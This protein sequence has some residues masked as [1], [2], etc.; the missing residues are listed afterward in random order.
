MRVFNSVPIEKWSGTFK[1]F[2]I[3]I[4]IIIIIIITTMIIII[5][6]KNK[7]NKMK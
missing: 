4:I 5:I 6:K 3:I 7:K 1:Q 2:K